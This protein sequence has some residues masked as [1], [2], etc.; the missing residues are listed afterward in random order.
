MTALDSS[1]FRRLAGL[2]MAA[3]LMTAASAT[4]AADDA[5][6]PEKKA[7]KKALAAPALQGLFRDLDVNS[8]KVLDRQ[9]V[10]EGGRKAFDA[11]LKYADTNHDEK[12]QAAEYR[13]V[14]KKLKAEKPKSEAKET[15]AKATESAAKPAKPAVTAAKPAETAKPSEPAAKPAETAAKPAE[16]ESKSEAAATPTARRQV[17]RE[18]L[19]AM[20]KDGDGRISRTEFTGKPKQF[21]RLD[22]NH[23][24]YLDREDVKKAREGKVNKAKGK[25]KA[26]S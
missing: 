22:T 1:M 17:I 24:G 18:K 3:M 11:V 5:K 9:E 10:P 16:S 8:D 4:V 2:S 15:K 20:D 14:L 21:D 26:T 23:D 19:K 12:L 7:A 13:D 6:Q 25:T